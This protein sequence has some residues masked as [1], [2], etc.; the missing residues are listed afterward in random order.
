[1]TLRDTRTRSLDDIGNRLFSYLRHDTMPIQIA[2][3][4]M[5]RVKALDTCAL[6]PLTFSTVQQPLT[7]FRISFPSQ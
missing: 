3:S 1:M 2:L 7:T 6:Q 4:R 5:P